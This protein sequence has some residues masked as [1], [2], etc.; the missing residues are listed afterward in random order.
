MLHALVLILACQLAGETVARATGLG[1]PGPVLGMVL[2]LAAMVALPQ[3]A[4]LMRPTAQGILG[5][6]SLLFVPAGVG[7]VG[8]V[9]TLGSQTF[10]ILAAVVGSTVLAIAAGALTFAA[11]ARL[12]GAMDQESISD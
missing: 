5:H 11:V 10:A 7:V 9:A 4:A 12:T 2:M 6:L 1:L 8:H 3:V